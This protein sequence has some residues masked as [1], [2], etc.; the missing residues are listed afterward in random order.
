MGRK[1][2]YKIFEIEYLQTA[3]LNEDD[4]YYLFDTPSL[5]Y[6]L[7]IEMF[8]RTKQPLFDEKKII[9]LVKDDKD[10][11]YKYFWTQKQ[12]D[13]FTDMI[14]KIYENVY[15]Y[16]EKEALQQ[17]QW[18]ISLYGLTNSD[19]KRNKNIPKLEE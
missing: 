3:E 7:L 1:K 14:V 12:R 13:E 5:N 19:L 17:A 18:W 9:K 11:M 8:R 4:L 16:K 15:Y 2:A 10:W 6:S